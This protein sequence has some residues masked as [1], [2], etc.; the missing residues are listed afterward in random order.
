MERQKI[1][2]TYRNGERLLSHHI[3]KKY[4]L[5]YHYGNGTSLNSRNVFN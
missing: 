1:L 4:I 2:D 5:I 3:H